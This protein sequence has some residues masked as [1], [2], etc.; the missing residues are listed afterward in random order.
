MGAVFF[1]QQKYMS[2]PSTGMSKEQQSQ[3]K[4]M[5]VLMVVMFPLMLYSAPSGLTLYILTSSCI[6]IL[7]SK[8]VRAHIK[9][10]D[11][12]PKEPKKA[13]GKTPRDAK[14]RAYAAAIKRME[15]KRQQKK[16]GP[17]KHYKKRK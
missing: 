12:K 17:E 9:D 7:E 5:R 10:M 6:G 15:E 16:R 4:M 2:P 11:L 14:G 3:Q 13:P 8:Y 1:F